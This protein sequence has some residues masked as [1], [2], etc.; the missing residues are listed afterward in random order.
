[1]K[2]LMIVARKELMDLFRDRRTVMLGLLMMPLLFPALILGMGALAERKARTQIEGE[3]ELPVIGAEHA[4]NLV[5]YLETHN[6]RMLPAPDDPDA[7]VR[8]QNFDAVLRIAPDFAER[9]RESRS[10]SVE[11]IY[12]SSR[13]DSRIPVARVRGAVEQYSRTLGVLRLIER[14]VSPEVTQP[15][16]VAQRDAATPE[17]RRGMILGV[18]LPYFLILSAFLGGAYLVIDVTAGERERQS[19]E[20][21]LSTPAARAGI[22]SGK[23]LAAIAFG[24]LSLL[25][26]L[27]ALKLSFTVAPGKLRVVNVSL[28]VMLQLLGVLLP[29]VLVGTTLLTLISASVKSVKEAQSYMSVLMLLP[30]IPTIMLMVNP[31]KN[32]LW[33]FAVPFLAQNQMILKLVRSEVISMQEW[34]VYLGASFGLGLVLWL[35]AARLY[36]Q[37]K[38]AIS[39]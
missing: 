21:L 7:E 13:Q 31:I 27:V 23:I 1:M 12:D 30:I 8:A 20:P 19:L 24:M 38:L 9:W 22:M 29:M 35:L 16:R 33:Q 25:L 34:A 5:S 11:L 6:I 36:H 28:P 37:E 4:P 14:G 32:Q 17:A 3:L 2:T 26:I 15:V 18:M 10:A 39:A